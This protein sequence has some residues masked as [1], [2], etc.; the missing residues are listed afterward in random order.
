MPRQVK[1]KARSASFTWDYRSLY[2][3]PNPE[4]IDDTESDSGM[5]SLDEKEWTSLHHVV[6]CDG[7]CP[8]IY[9]VSLGGNIIL[10]G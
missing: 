3:E 4:S 5:S 7:A 2:T 9:S 6:R 1:K 10:R 8:A